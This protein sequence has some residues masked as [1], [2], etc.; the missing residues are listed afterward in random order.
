MRNKNAGYLILAMVFGLG[1][2]VEVGEQ[3]LG[4]EDLGEASWTEGEVLGEDEDLHPLEGHEMMGD[5]A[6]EVEVTSLE[7][8]GN[9]VPNGGF[10]VGGT[11]WRPYGTPNYQTSLYIYRSTTARYSGTYG[12]RVH[13]GYARDFIAY[14]SQQPP[15]TAR[16]YRSYTLGAWTRRHTGDQQIIRVRFWD[17]SGNPIRTLTYYTGYSTSWHRITKSFTTPAGTAHMGVELG[18]FG[19]I[20]T[21]ST[22]DWD[23]VSLVAN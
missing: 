11:S 22:H 21:T 23:A 2:A 16:P 3:D 1:C 9:L 14:L 4:E 10:E 5:G 18:D 7:A 6:E 17:S 20:V 19:S 15:I 12:V 8:T 13:S